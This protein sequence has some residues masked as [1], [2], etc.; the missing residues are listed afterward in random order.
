[1]IELIS[2]LIKFDRLSKYNIKA[3]TAGVLRFIQAN[4]NGVTLGEIAKAIIMEPHSISG[5]V[6][7]MEKRGLIRKVKDLGDKRFTKIVLT[8]KGQQLYTQAMKGESVYNNLSVIS[9][10][11]CQQM[12]LKLEKIID[13][14]LRELQW[15]NE[16][17]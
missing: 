7:R 17:N 8:E 12:I 5:I 10:E 2:E 16:K 6:K 15:N 11:D 3:P 9:D 13:N 1:M 4:A 14:A